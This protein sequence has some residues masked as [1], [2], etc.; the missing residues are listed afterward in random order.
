MSG[1]ARKYEEQPSLWPIRPQVQKWR[2]E[3]EQLA[4]LMYELARKAAADGGHGATVSDLRIVAVQRGIV[5]TGREKKRDLSYL[6]AVP[7]AAGL[8]PVPGQFRRSDIP[9]SHGNLQR[10]WRVPSEVNS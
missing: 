8:E 2:A 7:K 10:L 4:P 3:I 9:D 6:G 5:L 1:A